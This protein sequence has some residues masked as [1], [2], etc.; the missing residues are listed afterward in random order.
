MP[1]ALDNFSFD[2]GIN[3]RRNSATLEDGEMQSCS[4]FSLDHEGY[5]SPLKS[6]AKVTSAGYGTIDNIHRY[7]NTV[8]ITEGSNIRYRWDLTGYC[9]LYVNPDYN[10]TLAGT[11]YDA[12][13]RMVDYSGWV[14]IVNNHLNKAFYRDTLYPWGVASPTS[15]PSVSVGSASSPS[16]TYTCYYTYLVKF[17]SG[18]E[19]ETGP[20]PSASVT[21]TSQAITWTG[22]KPCPYT[23]TTGTIIHRRLYRY[24]TGLAATYFVAEI[25][26]NTTTTYSDT[27]SDVTVQTNDTLSTISYSTPP[28]GL[29]DIE[30][31]IYRLFG[32]KGEFLHWSEPYIPFGWKTTSSINVCGEELTAVMYWGDQLYVAS[33]SK[34][35]RLS[36]T[37]PDT[38]SIKQTFSDK[39]VI[40]THTTKAT[41]YGLLGLWYDG[42]YVFDGS[43]SKNITEKQLGTSLFTD[44]ISDT[45]ACYAEWD[46]EK[47]YFYYPESGSTI[48]KCLVIDYTYYPELRMYH[49]PFLASAHQFHQPT[50]HRYLARTDTSTGYE[51]EESATGASMDCSLRTGA[52]TAK[53]ILKRKQLKRIYHMINTHAKD[54]TMT[55]YVD[56]VAQS[57]VFT[58]N[59][60]TLVTRRIE[61]IPQN[62]EGYKYD[63][64]LSV[65]GVTDDDLEVYAPIVL[66]YTPVGE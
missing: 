20:S 6:R 40:N 47:Y 38:W 55:V 44:T 30:F 66:E 50:G 60:S 3:T 32:I 48:S 33:K 49:D 61:D 63:V 9:G 1:E 14:Y 54:V 29:A 42:I 52:R 39:G 57:P 28:D 51:Y 15:A 8:L 65:S 46:G 36:G 4:G 21:V 12:K 7:L 27:L 11:G 56:D 62:W 41:K 31:Y 5:I 59:T 19:Y 2:K 64:A 58:I 25:A 16:G 53:N 35:Y 13:A 34:W 45:S 17:P 22:I 43:I 37:D 18:M 24:S 23:V 10:F 26:D